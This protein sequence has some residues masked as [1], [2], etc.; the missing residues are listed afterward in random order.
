MPWL[1]LISDLQSNALSLRAPLLDSEARSGLSQ[2][3]RTQWI[4]PP[5][6]SLTLFIL[7]ALAV[8]VKTLPYNCPW[9]LVW[10]ALLML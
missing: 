3:L 7:S 5:P 8:L 2:S 1:C 10:V 9:S 6:R 4:P